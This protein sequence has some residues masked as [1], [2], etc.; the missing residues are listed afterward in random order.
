MVEPTIKEVV[1]E[2]YGEIARQVRNGVEEGCCAPSCCA[3][4]ISTHI[5][6][7]D[8][9]AGLPADAVA[10]SL[11]CG[12][13]TALGELKPGETVLALGSGGGIDVLLSAKR[14]GPTGKV[15]IATIVVVARALQTQ[16]LLTKTL[17]IPLL[18]AVLR[19]SLL[20]P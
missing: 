5:Y 17:Q 10:A 2:K 19:H 14:V 6:S 20:L 16:L 4:P 13:P 9:T 18:E 3:D 12:N 15:R 8:D 1:K 11:G 7:E